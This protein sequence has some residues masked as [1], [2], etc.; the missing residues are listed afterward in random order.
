VKHRTYRA[1]CIYKDPFS[2]TP[3]RIW[4]IIDADRQRH[5]EIDK[6][7]RKTHKKYKEREYVDESV[8]LRFHL[9]PK[10]LNCSAAWRTVLPCERILDFKQHTEKEFV[11]YQAHAV[12]FGRLIVNNYAIQDSRHPKP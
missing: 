11:V 6:R 12:S 7:N 5:I 4:M 2:L 3:D 10:N 8:L 1:S 9:E